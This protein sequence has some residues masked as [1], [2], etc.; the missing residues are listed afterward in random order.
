MVVDPAKRSVVSFW[1]IGDFRI[2]MLRKKVIG[3]GLFGFNICG[4]HSNGPHLTKNL[5]LLLY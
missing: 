2:K 4:P 5:Q 1:W 3:W